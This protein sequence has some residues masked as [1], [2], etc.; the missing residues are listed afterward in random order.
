MKEPLR[1]EKRAPPRPQEGRKDLRGGKRSHPH[2][3]LDV[4]KATD[5]TKESAQGA[6][7]GVETEVGIGKSDEIEENDTKLNMYFYHV[8]QDR[9]DERM[10][11]ITFR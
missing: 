4:R 1:A 3:H 9:A 2:P 8:H 6:E 11:E 5:R 10:R 7:K